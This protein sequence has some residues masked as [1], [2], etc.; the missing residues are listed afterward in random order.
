MTE[1]ER[2]LTILKKGHADRPAYLSRRDDEYGNLGHYGVLRH[3]S[4]RCP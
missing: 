1:K 3:P 2:L 4:S